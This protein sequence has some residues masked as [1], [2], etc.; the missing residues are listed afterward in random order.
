MIL[1]SINALQ[2][3]AEM[4]ATC[5]PQPFPPAYPLSTYRMDRLTS[6]A[7]AA[8]TLFSVFILTAGARADSLMCLHGAANAL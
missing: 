8:E 7:S 1:L 4:R 5:A 6:H 2:T 3:A